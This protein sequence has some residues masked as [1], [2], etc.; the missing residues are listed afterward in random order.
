MKS[1][2][3]SA[4]E[5]YLGTVLFMEARAVTVSAPFMPFVQIEPFQEITSIKNGDNSLTVRVNPHRGIITSG[6][7]PEKGEILIKYNVGFATDE[8][9]LPVAVKGIIKKYRKK[10]KI[11]FTKKDQEILESFK[12]A[13]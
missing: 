6:M 9:N 12:V 5:S 13:S 8:T 11:V 10:K 7:W 1:P 4:L 2:I 3:I